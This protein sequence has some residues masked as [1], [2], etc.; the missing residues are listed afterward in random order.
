MTDRIIGS[1]IAA[2]IGVTCAVALLWWVGSSSGLDIEQ[3]VAAAGVPRA[4][5]RPAVRVDIKG[6]FLKFDGVPSS[7][8]GS[9]PGFRGPRYDNI[10]SERIRVSD[11]WGEDGPPVLWSVEL[12]EG[13]A[14]PAVHNGMVFVLDYDEKFPGDS[15]RC[16]SLE[17]GREIWRRWYKVRVKRNHGMSRTVPAVTDRYV[18][19]IG[20]KCHVMCVDTD[21][22]KF[23]WGIDLVREY[24]TKVPMWYTGQCPII[25]GSIAVIAPGGDSLMIGVDCDNGKVVWRTPNPDGWKMSHASI[26]PMTLHG[27]R[28]YVYAAIGGIV[29]V[30]AEED[31][32]GTAL[33]KST[34]WN[35]A[36]VAPSPVPLGDGRIFLTAGYGVGSM[37][38]EVTKGADGFTAKSKYRLDRKVFA[39]EQHTP[40]FHDGHLYAVLPKDAG[41]L[42]QQFACMTPDGKVVWSSG[43]TR[44]FG[45]GP[46][47]IAGDT[48]LVLSD[49]GQLTF[50]KAAVDRYVELARVKVLSGREAWAPMALVNGRLL[51]RDFNVM[52]CLDVGASHAGE[53]VASAPP[54][55]GVRR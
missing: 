50:I 13:Y 53:T 11:D 20:P 4:G 2:A 32:R 7:L 10:S 46:F 1:S 22:G 23:R 38:L 54:A 24:G 40:V 49:D 12:G 41:A 30:S 25:D 51:V 55:G 17:T 42:R 39:C 45:L 27:V 9:W 16:L 34:E 44:R 29:G 48:I 18:V 35:H 19:T 5:T 33:W 31:N 37:M 47:M 15:L 3:R 6:T 8:S 36:V 52:V 26:I 14:G 21:T 28:M 43:K